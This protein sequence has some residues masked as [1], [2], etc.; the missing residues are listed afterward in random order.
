MR[1]MRY[2]SSKRR[3]PAKRRAKRRNP[4]H[5]RH[6]RNDETAAPAKKKRVFRTKAELV[7]EARRRLERLEAPP[8]EKKARAKG[9]PRKASSARFR[10]VSEKGMAKAVERTLRAIAKQPSLMME[11]DSETKRLL[12]PIL[13]ERAAKKRT[14]KETQAQAR[15][16]KS[17]GKRLAKSKAQGLTKLGRAARIILRKKSSSSAGAKSIARAWR[18]AK[19][20]QKGA[21]S[22]A[23]RKLLTAMGLAGVPNSSMGGIFK[24]L[25][26][27]LPAMGVSAVSLAAAAVAGQMIASKI[28]P[29]EKQSVGLYK[30]VPSGISF[31]V[32]LAAYMV[33]RK[34]KS[35][36]ISRFAPWA[37]A[38]GVAAAAVHAIA[39]ITVKKDGADVSLGKALGLPIG[40][41]ASMAGYGEY[42]SMAGYGEYASMAGGTS[43]S[44]SRGVFAGLDDNDPVLSGTDDEDEVDMLETDADEGVNTDEGSLNGSIFD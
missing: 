7:A 19:V 23:E 13:A 28:V 36:S 34:S 18:M 10:P 1:R 6:R 24:D 3:K 8:K 41:Y 40:E 33:L 37:L 14:R 38:G 5:S 43:Y 26:T 15:R 32:G 9:G 20:A 27:L 42:A 4:A 17:G 12:G 21:N 29:A 31:G 2:N 44:G 16:K 39:R 11:L 35:T 22:P 30:F 25:R